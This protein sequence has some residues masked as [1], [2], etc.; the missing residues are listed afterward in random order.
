MALKLLIRRSQYR[1]VI[2][3]R[4]G[5]KQSS[6]L[7]IRKLTIF[8]NW[9]SVHSP[10][11]HSTPSLTQLT[12][13][14]FTLEHTCTAWMDE[15]LRENVPENLFTWCRHHLENEKWLRGPTRR[16][17]GK[18]Q[19]SWWSRWVGCHLD[20]CLIDLHVMCVWLPSSF[21]IGSVNIKSSKMS[22]SRIL[23]K[24]WTCTNE[25]DKR[26][27]WSENKYW[28]FALVLAYGS[29]CVPCPETGEGYFWIIQYVSRKK[30][31]E[32]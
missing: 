22:A 6:N 14:N 1:R 15:N 29:L 3:E 16:Q 13:N 7:S 32:N 27:T 31:T 28:T 8:E 11:L 25:P 18:L 9:H 2:V 24:R 5:R 4:N 26:V 10:R 19:L 21:I 30:S 17:E 23:A 20:K 12:F